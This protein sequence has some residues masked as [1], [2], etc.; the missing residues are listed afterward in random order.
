[1][2]LALLDFCSEDVIAGAVT[3]LLST[4]RRPFG[5]RLCFLSVISPLLCGVEENRVPT[6]RTDTRIDSHLLSPSHPAS[7]LSLSL[8]FLSFFVA[9]QQTSTLR[10]PLL[11]RFFAFLLL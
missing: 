5:P 1:V 11:H 7:S 6:K 3:R 8:A 4:A 9:Q 10:S 2:L